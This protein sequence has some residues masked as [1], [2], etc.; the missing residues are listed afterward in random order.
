MNAQH[1]ELIRGIP[2]FAGFTE[3]GAQRLLEAGTVEE[4]PAETLLFQEG[5]PPAFVLLVLAG[6]LKVFVNRSGQQL[7]LIEA[8]PGSLLGE[9]AVLGSM[10]RAASVRTMEKTTVLKWTDAAFRRLLLGNAFLSERIFAASVRMLIE[11]EQA[12]IQALIQAQAKK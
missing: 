5:D 4:Y 6:R 7:T 10:P 9:L 12:L 3:H 11:K 8:T 2:I 1:V